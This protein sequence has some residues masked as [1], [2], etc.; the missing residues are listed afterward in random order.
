MIHNKIE[1]LNK[2]YISIQIKRDKNSLL[3]IVASDWCTFSRPEIIWKVM[4]LNFYLLKCYLVNESF[5]VI[6]F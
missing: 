6:D 1:N 3:I 4:D 2:C 5:P